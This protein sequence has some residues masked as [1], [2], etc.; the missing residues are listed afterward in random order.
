MSKKSTDKKYNGLKHGGFAVE[1]ILPGERQ[2]DFDA[3]HEG[4]IAEWA[5]RGS[6]EEDAVRTLARLLWRKQRTENY[7]RSEALENMMKYVVASGGNQ[8]IK[9]AAAIAEKLEVAT[10]D[11]EIEILLLR[12]PAQFGEAIRSSIPRANYTDPAQWASALVEYLDSELLP[13]AR[14]ARLNGTFAASITPEQIAQEL[15]LHERMEALIDRT[16]KRL[17]AC[18]INQAGYGR[19]TWHPTGNR[20]AAKT[21]LTQTARAKI[22]LVRSAG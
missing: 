2:E 9:S 3:L 13:T 22:V 1:L 8:D 16:I 19:R 21:N 10:N 6:I 7:W 15:A 4:L 20:R 12:L 17:V 5:P 18:Q 14:A 11:R